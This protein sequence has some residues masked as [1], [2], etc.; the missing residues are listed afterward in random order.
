MSR[1]KRYY[2][3]KASGKFIITISWDEKNPPSIDYFFENYDIFGSEECS[4]VEVSLKQLKTIE[5]TIIK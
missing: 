4:L 1:A 5:K 2:A 3:F